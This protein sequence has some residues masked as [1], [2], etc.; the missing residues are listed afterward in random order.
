MQP[1]IVPAQGG[2]QLHQLP[3]G[4]HRLRVQA[5]DVGDDGA[6]SQVELPADRLTGEGGGEFI[7]VDAVDGQ[8]DVLLGD[9]ILADQIVPDV[10]GHGQ[11][12]L[13]PVGQ[14]TQ[15]PADLIHP[16][17]GGDEGEAHG[18]LQP[19]A[20]KGG[21]AGVGVDDVGLLP[22][23]DLAQ[24][25]LGLEHTAHRPAVQGGGVVPDACGLDLRDVHAPIG[26]HRHLVAPAFQF[27]GQ[28]HD[29][30]LC[31][32]DVQAHGGHENLHRKPLFPALAD[33]SHGAGELGIGGVEIPG[34]VDAQVIDAVELIAALADETLAL[35]G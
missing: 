2:G 35:N 30:G 13:P 28:L 32:A 16:V 5:A 1:G 29:V 3:G 10:L 4:V 25:A 31:A 26:H 17:A 22:G 8:S 18:L 14:Q 34:G 19:P 12:A 21:D 6:V 27:L 11:G 20:Q 23:D 24:D 33:G 9:I 7:R 15:G